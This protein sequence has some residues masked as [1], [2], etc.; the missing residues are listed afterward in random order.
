MAILFALIYT[1]QATAEQAALTVRGMADAG[2]IDILD[3]SLIT[4]NSKGHLE[5]HGERH[6]VRA[7]LATGAVLG[8][9]TGLL[10][11]VPV[12]GVAAGAALGGLIG[13]WA[14][15]GAGDDF[16]KFRDQVSAD[17]EP[18]GAALVILG[19]TEGRERVIHDLGRHG[20][21]IRS[22]DLSDEQLAD[23][24]QE[25]NKVSATEKSTP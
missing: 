1:D 20:G 23:I 8:G 17:L 14:S 7:G 4:K 24:Q 18:G 2:F 10:F 16:G 6:T 12:A 21:I 15:S 5:H 9:M 13:K 22:T 25:I 19:E 11:F 3:S